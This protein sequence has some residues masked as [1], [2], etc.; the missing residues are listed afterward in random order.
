MANCSFL[1]ESNDILNNLKLVVPEMKSSH[2]NLFKTHWL[3]LF[4][5]GILLDGKTLLTM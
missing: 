2:A 3:N 4:F 1:K 5:N